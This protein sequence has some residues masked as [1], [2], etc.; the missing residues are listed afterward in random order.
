MMKKPRKLDQSSTCKAG[1]ILCGYSQKYGDTKKIAADSDWAGSEER[2]STHT[3]L[4]FHGEHLVDSWVAS[5]Q[6]RTL[7]SQEAELYGIVDGSARRIFI[8]HMYKEMGRTI[9]VDVETDSTA[10]IKMCSERA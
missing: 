9:N 1:K 8:K 7:S 5:D 4:E 6:V 3:G 10:A 2:C